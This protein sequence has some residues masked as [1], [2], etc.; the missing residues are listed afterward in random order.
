MARRKNIVIVHQHHRILSEQF[1]EYQKTLGYHL[2]TCRARQLQVEEFMYWIECKGLNELEQVQ[3]EHL[4]SYYEYLSE[5]PNKQQDGILHQKTLYDYLKSVEYLFTMLQEKGGVLINPM[6]TLKFDYPKDKNE[7]AI[8]TQA[9]IQQL[10]KHCETARERAILSLGYGCGL[11]VGEMEQLNVEDIRFRDKMVIVRKG[12]GNKRRI[13]PMSPG[14]IK[15]L[16]EYFY[17]ERSD[18]VGHKELAFM[19]NS[20][21]GRMREFTYNKH[22][23]MMIERTNNETLKGKELGIH[24]LRHSIATHL[25]EQGMQV[26][27]V[28]DF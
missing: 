17:E 19:I 16:E 24:S 21:G 28:R 6:N 12:K 1:Y 3:A 13:V 11:R 26:E 9:Q 8:L 5:R 10:Y 25:I 18:L 22:L 15:D 27:L 20:K 7:R 14:V 2:D 23:R 4:Q